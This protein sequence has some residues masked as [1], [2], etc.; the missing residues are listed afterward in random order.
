MVAAEHLFGLKPVIEE[1]WKQWSGGV[2]ATAFADGLGFEKIDPDDITAAV[3]EKF[4]NGEPVT[5]VQ[6]VAPSAPPTDAPSPSTTTPA[7][8]PAPTTEPSTKLNGSVNG[9]AGS[10]KLNNK[11][12]PL[13]QS[14]TTHAAKSPSPGPSNGS[15]PS[16][17]QR[18]PARAEVDS[19]SDAEEQPLEICE[20]LTSHSGFS[21]LTKTP[22]GAR[23]SAEQL[24]REQ[25][26]PM[27]RPRLATTEAELFRSSYEAL[28]DE[29]KQ[30]NANGSDAPVLEKV[31]TTLETLER[32]VQRLGEAEVRNAELEH[33]L[34]QRGEG[35]QTSPNNGAN[36]SDGGI[37]SNPDPPREKSLRSAFAIGRLYPVVA[38]SRLTPDEIVK[39][40]PNRPWLFRH[41]GADVKI[42]RLCA[43]MDVRKYFLDRVCGEH[44]FEACVEMNVAR[45][46]NNARMTFQQILERSQRHEFVYVEQHYEAQPG[47]FHNLIKELP[48]GDLQPRPLRDAYVFV[49]FF[50]CP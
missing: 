48:P 38:A 5:E 22:R 39:T 36:K 12:A 33:L 45:R 20:P 43:E 47:K 7:T 21:Y 17:A 3:A 29:I 34:E 9:D 6:Q 40:D 42:V 35:D 41:L 27:K 18:R 2:I 15:H 28:R 44:I 25:C 31:N 19:D 14:T 49:L 23:Q 8:S 16:S 4:L 37:V 30:L 13:V 10:K 26:T 32:C 24:L 50:C 46:S 1:Y 11:D